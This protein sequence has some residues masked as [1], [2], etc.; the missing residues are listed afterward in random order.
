MTDKTRIKDIVEKTGF[1]RQVV[2]AVL[3]NKTGG[4]V[5]FSE[6]TRQSILR[7]VAD[8]GY[9]PNRSVQTIRTGRH[10][11]IGLL[12]TQTGNLIGDTMSHLIHGAGRFGQLLVVE[13]VPK[14]AQELPTIISEDAVDGILVYEVLP[15]FITEQLLNFNIPFVQVNNGSLGP[16]TVS[17][18]D[19]QGACISVEMLH[20]RGYGSLAYLTSDDTG[21]HANTLRWQAI[22]AQCKA[23]SMTPPVRWTL[24]DTKNI[25]SLTQLTHLIETNPNIDGFVVDHRWMGS[26]LFHAGNIHGKEMRT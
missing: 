14:D 16:S 8:L 7:T 13:H 25:D 9:R 20:Q 4:G 6:E 26:M 24:K 11:S 2:S 23:L 1:S 21:H 15:D 22:V 17:L 10:N 19:E 12:A 18:N 5:R 3:N